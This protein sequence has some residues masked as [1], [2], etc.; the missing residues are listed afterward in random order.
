MRVANK[1]SIRGGEFKGNKEDLDQLGIRLVYKGGQHKAGTVPV[2][3]CFADAFTFTPL[4]A[5]AFL[6]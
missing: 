2:F 1:H 6:F 3:E 5:T 4:L